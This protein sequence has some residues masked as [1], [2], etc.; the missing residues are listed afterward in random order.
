M[1]RVFAVIEFAET[2]RFD[3]SSGEHLEELAED[4]LSAAHKVTSVAVYPTAEEL[5]ADES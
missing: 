3:P 1:K 2:S 4:L 5:M